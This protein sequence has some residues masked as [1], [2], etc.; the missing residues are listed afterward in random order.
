MATRVTVT[1]FYEGDAD[2]IF[3]QAMQFAE[4][5]EAMAGLAEYR[6]LP[7]QA[8]EEGQTLTVDVTF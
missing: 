8:A 6:G 3:A 1:A 5:R 4:L 2:A 7:D